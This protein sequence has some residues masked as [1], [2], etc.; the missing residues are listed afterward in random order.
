MSSPR[1]GDLCATNV[2]DLKHAIGICFVAPGNETPETGPETPETGP[3]VIMLIQQQLII[4]N[5]VL[6]LQRI[7]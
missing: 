4:R 2:Q 1:Y 7:V 5:R 3:A 6:F